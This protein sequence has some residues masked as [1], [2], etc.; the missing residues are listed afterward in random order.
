[1]EKIKILAILIMVL[2]SSCEKTELPQEEPQQLEGI[3]DGRNSIAPTQRETKIRQYF[4]AQVND[5]DFIVRDSLLLEA[6]MFSVAEEESVYLTVAG[7]VKKGEAFETIFFT[8]YAFKGKGTYFTGNSNN[9]NYAY[10][11][12][13]SNTIWYSKPGMGDP[14]VVE[15][16]DANRT[17]LKGHFDINVYDQVTY[18]EPVRMKGEFAINLKK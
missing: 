11:W 9:D 13:T 17:F 18:M 4:T 6:K 12:N 2:F 5:L 14:G 8:I 16:T 3:E 10:F 15:I 7:S 1:M